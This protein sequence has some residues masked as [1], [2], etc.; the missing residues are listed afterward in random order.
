MNRGCLEDR[1]VRET[2]LRDIATGNGK[3]ESTPVV[4]CC[5]SGIVVHLNPT[6]L[7]CI[8]TVGW[9]SDWCHVDDCNAE[10]T[11]AQLLI[12][13]ISLVLGVECDR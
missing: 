6:H 5:V 12:I 3:G 2:W 4:V 8:V 9:V 13:C 10:L 1:R 7:L 11:Y